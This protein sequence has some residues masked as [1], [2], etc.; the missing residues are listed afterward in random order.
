MLFLI[1]RGYKSYEL[2]MGVFESAKDSDVWSVSVRD[3]EPFGF[4]E[5]EHDAHLLDA[6]VRGFDIAEREI[7]E[8]SSGF[9]Y[10]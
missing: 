10:S 2:T 6:I 9:S 8:R 1:N 5:V 3:E 7:D 4:F